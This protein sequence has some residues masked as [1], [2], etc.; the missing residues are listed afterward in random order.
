VKKA[1]LILLCFLFPQFLTRA[2]SVFF[3]DDQVRWATNSVPEFPADMKSLNADLIVLQEGTEFYFY[4]VTN[5]K[6]LRNIVVKVNTEKGLEQLKNFILPESLDPAYDFHLYKQGRRTRTKSPYIRE[7]KVNS[8]AARKYAHGKWTN[9]VFKTTYEQFKWIS[10]EGKFIQDEVSNYQFSGI[11]VGDIVEIY[12]DAS[13]NSNYGNNLFYFNS[14]YPKAKCEYNFIFKIGKHH[15]GYSFVLPLNIPDSC[16][17]TTYAEFKE[18]KMCTLKVKLRRLN[19]INYPANSFEGKKLPHVFMDFKYYR[20]ISNSWPGESGRIYDY[21]MIRP[22][23]FEW[24]PFK[25]TNNYYTK[26]Y[27][28]HFHTLRKFVSTLPKTGSDSANRIFFKALCDT[29]N[30][31]RFITSNQLYYNESALYDLYSSDHLAKRRLVSHLTWK[32]CRDILDDN[33]I[34][35]YDVNV[36]DKRYG[37]HTTFQRAHYA[38][39]QMLIAIPSGTSF[40]YFV[41][42]TTGVKYHLNELPFYLEGALGALQPRNFQPDVKDKESQ[43][44]KF[45]KTHKGTYNENTRTEN[46]TVK[47]SLDSLKANLV[48]KESLSGQF[49]TTLRHYYL[50]DYIDST[51]APYY[52]RKCTD[53]P[54]SSNA[55]IKLSSRITDFP[56]RY[57]FNCS[58]KISLYNAGFIDMKNWFSFPLSKFVFPEMPLHDYYFDFDFSDSYNFQLDFGKPVELANVQGFSRNISNELFELESAIVKNSESSYLVKV[59][60]AVKDIRVPTDKAPMLMDL[61]KNLDELNSY[62]LEIAKK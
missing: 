10:W 2:Q 9:L 30:S 62:L 38:Y 42:R 8:F 35:Y 12:Y 52:F 50:G 45:I 16:I 41:P 33:K 25:D 20:V 55:K 54:L 7:F 23:H 60:L 21:V 15:E 3:G 47:I 11:A 19:A 36:Q 26:I 34:F 59:R 1:V 43:Y 37:E 40:I 28:K 18:Y 32:L 17:K 24:P 4:S 56:F 44:S 13:F 31:F 46:A 6:V 22:R 51:V 57:T 53:K 49:S 5:E 58:E 27:D 48:I 61:V 14:Q 39:E 29:F